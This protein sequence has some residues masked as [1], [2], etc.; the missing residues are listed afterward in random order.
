MT[1]M[2]KYA[3]S[4]HFYTKMITRDV[5]DIRYYPARNQ[6]SSWI[7]YPVQNN[8]RYYPVSCRILYSVLSGTLSTA[9]NTPQL[10]IY[11]VFNISW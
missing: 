7:Q 10:L 9:A 4:I 3:D 8:I 2:C 6:V 11:M 5:L 1:H